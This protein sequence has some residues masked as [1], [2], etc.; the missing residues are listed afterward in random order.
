[1]VTSITSLGHSGLFDWVVQRATAV[2]LAA[3]TVFIVFF[4]LTSPDLT[5]EQWRALFQAT[6]MRIFSLAALIA[7][8][9]HAWV[10]LWT[11]STDYLQ[12][13]APRFA[14][15]AAC[16]LLAFVYLVW[17]IEVIWS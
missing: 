6:W 14:F 4:L 16:G 7:L 5:Y 17:G 1:M 2:I 10:G 9:S 11:I 12:S 13:A 3:Y 8:L 15:Q